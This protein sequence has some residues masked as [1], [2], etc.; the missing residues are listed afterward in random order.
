MSYWL[1][2]ILKLDKLGS[3]EETLQPGMM[4]IYLSLPSCEV[5]S[6]LTPMLV[7]PQ[8]PSYSSPHP[9]V[10]VVIC[11]TVDISFLACSIPSARNLFASSYAVDTSDS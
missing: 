10:V 8:D 11:F 4:H 2:L 3:M 5:G 9:I 1:I 6:E 7:T